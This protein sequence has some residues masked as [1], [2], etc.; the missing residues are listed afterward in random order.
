MRCLLNAEDLAT[1]LVDGVGEHK[2]ENS[3]E[4]DQDVEGGAG[5][6]L[7]RVA[8]GVAH[9]GS[10]VLGARHLLAVLP[11]ALLAGLVRALDEL[12]HLAALNVLLGVVPRTSS[13]GRG[14]GHLNTAD[15][16][17]DEES[18]KGVLAKAEAD[19][20]RGEDHER[21]G[22]DHLSEGALG[23]DLD[24]SG[25]VG[26]GDPGVCVTKE[27]VVIKRVAGERGEARLPVVD[28]TLAFSV[29]VL[30]V[31][32]L[33]ANLHNLQSGAVKHAAAAAGQGRRGARTMVMAARP[34]LF[35]VMPLNT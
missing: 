8:D 20:K 21:C 35:I 3:H 11:Q 10:L 9:D 22:G 7:E 32:E 2:G 13:V 16:A 5:G 31:G 29:L 18:R 26:R 17:S 15:E 4:L 30:L 12:L 33:P 25:V 14:N 19:K 6:V 1:V 24:A 23:G 34:T 27:K 28:I